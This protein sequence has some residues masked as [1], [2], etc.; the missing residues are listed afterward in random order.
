MTG[1][2]FNWLAI[3]SVARAICWWGDMCQYERRYL[4]VT[5]PRA[6]FAII[7]IL[8]AFI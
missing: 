3:V 7:F 8:V 1:I 4:T 5:A 6:V 2:I